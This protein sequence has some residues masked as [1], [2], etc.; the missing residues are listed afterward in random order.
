MQIR[1][2]REGADDRDVAIGWQ[3]GD[4]LGTANVQTG[5]VRKDARHVLDPDP[6][7][8]RHSHGSPPWML[9]QPARLRTQSSLLIGV[10]QIR[11]MTCGH[12]CRG[13]AQSRIRLQHGV[14]ASN[15]VAVLASGRGTISYARRAVQGRVSPGTGDR[16]IMWGAADG[17]RSSCLQHFILQVIQGPSRGG[18][19]NADG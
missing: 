8:L 3:G 6:G 5:S 15:A 10:R 14:K 19:S 4:N 1:G 2:E 16:P 17:G 7:G 13:H 9:G 18:A 12:Q 11:A